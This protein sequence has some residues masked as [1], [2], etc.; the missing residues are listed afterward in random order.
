MRRNLFF[1]V[2]TYPDPTGEETIGSVANFAARHAADIAGLIVGIEI[3]HVS[4][5]WSLPLIDM[6]RMV[7]EAESSSRQNGERLAKVL[8]QRS[9]ERSVK[10]D[11]SRIRVEPAAVSDTCVELGRL[12]DMIVAQ[13]GEDQRALNEAM[14]FG[15]GRPV[16]LVPSVPWNGLADHVAIAWD[17]GRAAARAL[18]DALWLVERAARVTILFSGGD[19]AASTPAASQLAESLAR[20]GVQA[21]LRAVDAADRGIGDALQA[22]AAAAGADLLVMGGYGHSRLREFV[23][24]GA[25][26]GVL[27]R[28]QLPVLISH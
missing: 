2:T 1:P 7:K 16:L 22:G 8:E 25:T 11:L 24:G 12:H 13:S 26:A 21:D 27:S 23:L 15:C 19:K 9:S 28:P 14:I 18:G 10:L 5:P 20:R 4:N 6:P 17:G 3:P